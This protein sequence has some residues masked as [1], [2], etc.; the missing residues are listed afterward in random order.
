M[1]IRIG[2]LAKQTQCSVEA[3]RYYEREGL[4]PPPGRSDGNY[5]IYGKSHIERLMFIRHCRA[6]DMALDEVRELLRFRDNPAESCGRVNALLDE[7]IQAVTQRLDEL[8]RLKEH[9][10]ALRQS[11]EHAAA[12]EACGILRALSLNDRAEPAEQP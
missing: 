7:H 11:C 2:E 6:L 8:A 5:R 12:A 9:L 1:P 4:L 3:I 10:V